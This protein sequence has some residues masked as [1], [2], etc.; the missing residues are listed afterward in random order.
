MNNIMPC[1]VEYTIAI[2]NQFNKFS[3]RIINPGV[4][5]NDDLFQADEVFPDMNRWFPFALKPLQQIVFQCSYP[6]VD[7]YLQPE[8]F[9][10][11]FHL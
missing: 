2:S 8:K 5:F 7:P 9:S 3:F 10:K 11:R 6:Q 4:A 1:F